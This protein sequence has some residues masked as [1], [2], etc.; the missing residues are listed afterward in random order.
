M[1]AFNQYWNNEGNYYK[2]KNCNVKFDIT[3]HI[4]TEH[5]W[6][7]TADYADN[8]VNVGPITSGKAKTIRYWYGSWDAGITVWDAAHELG[9]LLKLKDDYTHSYLSGID[10]PN[11]G[12]EGHMMGQIW[13]PVAQHEIDQIIGSKGESCGC[14]K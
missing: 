3:P 7:F 2:Y 13:S 4:D 1:G 14:E 8:Y 10:T 6:W 9:H 5:N 12:H 11:S